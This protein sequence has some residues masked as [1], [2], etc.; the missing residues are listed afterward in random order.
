[1]LSSF[2]KL[3]LFL[4]FKGCRNEERANA[5][6]TKLGE[7]T[8]KKDVFDTL[9]IDIMDSK[10][11]RDAVSQLDAPINCLVL[12]AGGPGGS[13]FVAQSNDG[14]ANIMALNVTGN[15]LLVKELL[16]S[17]K[18]VK[19]STIVYCSSEAARGVDSFGF[20]APTIDDNGSVEEFKSAI[21]GSKFVKKGDVTYETTYSYAKCL[22]VLW[23]S[24]MARKHPEYR[25]V[26]VSPGAVTGTNLLKD[27]GIVKVLMFKTLGPLMKLFGMAQD[28]DGG[29]QRYL[30]VVYMLD[31]YES[32]KFYGSKE[33]KLTGKMVLQTSMFADLGNEVY[34]DNAAVAVE[35][36]L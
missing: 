12:N 1:M 21:D 25:F 35:S 29:A 22:G 19:G 24:S 34:Q 33:G 15:A 6:K 3:S 13:D 31:K 23:M 20:P 28:T 5:A 18:L 14:V 10:S 2:S 36:F 16:S 8:G 32:G 11:V 9:Q 17:N 4:S 7:E 27:L 26:S 30:D